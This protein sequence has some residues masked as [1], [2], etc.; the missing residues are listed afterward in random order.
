MITRKLHLSL[1]RLA[2]AAAMLLSVAPA[3]LANPPSSSRVEQEHHACAVVVGLDP[4]EAPYDACVRSLDSF[5][6]QPDQADLAQSPDDIGQ[7][8][9]IS[10]R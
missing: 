9:P 6:P 10:V 2:F 5:F 8:S 4:S 3:A 1:R 7:E